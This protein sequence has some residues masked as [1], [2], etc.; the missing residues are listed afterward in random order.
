MKKKFVIMILL[1]FIGIISESKLKIGVSMLPYYSFATNIVKDKADVYQIL[2]TDADVHTYQPSANEVKKISNLDV[3]IING[4][5]ID[6]YMYNLIKASGNKNIK[7][8]VASKNVSLLPVSGERGKVKSV[9][10]HTFISVQASIQQINTIAKELANLDK[11]NANIYLKN[12]REYGRK[13][14]NIKARKIREISNLRKKI[15]FNVATTHGGYDYILGEIG[16]GVSVVIEPRDNVRP[17][18]VDLKE[19]I[20]LIKEKHINVLFESDGSQ[21]PYT[22]QIEKETGVVS[23]KLLHMT[24]GKYTTTA[25]ENDLEKNFDIII[26]TFKKAVSKSK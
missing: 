19:S 9:N 14:S 26:S 16:I 7:V 24:N 20:K 1:I 5:G 21:S 6:N 11:S 8:L 15:Q 18:A 17:S 4:T 25:F 3:L 13:L 10:T 2:P 22:R 12:A 23:G